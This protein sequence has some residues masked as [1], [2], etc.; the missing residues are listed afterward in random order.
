MKI[1]ASLLLL[2]FLSSSSIYANLDDSIFVIKSTW[3]SN[4]QTNVPIDLISGLTGSVTSG[5]IGTISIGYGTDYS[6]G[7]GEPPHCPNIPDIRS[8]SINS[9]TIAISSPND[10]GVSIIYRGNSSGCFGVDGACHGLLISPVNSA[11][12][13][14]IKL[15]PQST[16]TVTIKGGGSGIVAIRSTINGNKGVYFPSDYSW[17]FSTGNGDPPQRVATPTVSPTPTPTRISIPDGVNLDVLV[18]QQK[19]IADQKRRIEELEKQLTLTPT[20]TKKLNPTKKITPNTIATAS[21]I[22][23]EPISSPS[24]AL[25]EVEDSKVNSL[26]FVP[27]QSLRS[28]GLKLVSFFRSLFSILS[29]K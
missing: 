1:I 22:V 16:Y 21:A 13:N 15:M 11:L 20:P 23:S 26:Y 14:G 25:T 28:F 12:P 24:S 17:S 27:L 3:P 4:G 2:F 18:R 5:G 6:G 8:D 19:E 29:T 7:C 10:P 9:S